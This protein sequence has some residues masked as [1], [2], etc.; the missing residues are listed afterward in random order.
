MYV[1]HLKQSHTTKNCLSYVSTTTRTA[2][3]TVEVNLNGLILHHIHAAQSFTL[4]FEATFPS[5]F[6]TWRCTKSDNFTISCLIIFTMLL[7]YASYSWKF[8]HSKVVYLLPVNQIYV[9]NEHS[10]GYSKW[11]MQ[12]G[13][14]IECFHCISVF[15]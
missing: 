8:I 15:W 4:Y 9:S 12:I 6:F 3:L 2:L 13:K 5:S 11:H 14:N 10:Y 7:Q 1:C